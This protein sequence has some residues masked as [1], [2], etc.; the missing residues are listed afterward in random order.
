MKTLKILLG[1]FLVTLLW[2]RPNTP[3]A[4]NALPP[5]TTNGP[6]SPIFNGSGNVN[7]CN[8]PPE[9]SALTSSERAKFASA[10]SIKAL[11]VGIGDMPERARTQTWDSR[12]W[13]EGE[14]ADVRLT[15]NN[16]LDYPLDNVDLVVGDVEGSPR[17]RIAG[18]GQLSELSGLDIR[19]VPIVTALDQL[20][21]IHMRGTD[22]KDYNLPIF[23]EL[24]AH[25]RIPPRHYRVSTSR[26][27]ANDSLRLIVATT[28]GGDL[29]R[30]PPKRLQI[31]GTY[32]TGPTN[33][34]VREQVD[35]IVPVAR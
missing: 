32:E 20:P 14:Y 4:Q 25:P 8:M 5:Q 10:L 6:C 22:G 23:D 16:I 9:G 2:E 29:K 21:V 18:I 28:Y 17:A 33:G 12:P 35:V 1:C 3:V 15:I 7:N 26:L 19:P 11:H 31:T 30:T 13:N 27:F 24:L 34:R